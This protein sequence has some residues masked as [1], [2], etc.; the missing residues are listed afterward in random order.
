MAGTFYLYCLAVLDGG[1]GKVTDNRDSSW[2][3]SDQI[4]METGRDRLEW[5]MVLDV[6]EEGNRDADQITR[7]LINQR[8]VKPF[9]AKVVA[10]NYLQSRL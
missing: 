6:W 5:F 3:S 10:A 7:F 4:R 2:M 9:W 1:C 8:G